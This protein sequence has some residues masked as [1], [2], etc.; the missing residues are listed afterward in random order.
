MIFRNVDYTVSL[1]S[2][3][4]Y[5]SDACHAE[6]ALSLEYLRSLKSDRDSYLLQQELS[7]RLETASRALFIDS[8]DDNKHLGWYISVS[9]EF[10]SLWLNVS[11]KSADFTF[12]PSAFR[13]QLCTRMYLP[14]TELPL[15]LECDCLINKK[16][17]VLDERCHHIVTGCHKN[18]C[19]I[20]LH[21]A[22]ANLL[23]E[24]AGSFRLLQI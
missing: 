9:D 7:S 18:G 15:G 6:P 20:N 23:K 3:I 8:H 21:H 2:S 11:P 4:D 10:A 22:E 1:Q 19:G 13:S 14:Q 17:P 5:I 16:H 12:S 24:M